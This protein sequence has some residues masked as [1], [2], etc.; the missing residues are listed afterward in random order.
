MPLLGQTE[1]ALCALS[2]ALIVHILELHQLHWTCFEGPFPA[3]AFF[4][5]VAK[6]AQQPFVLKR[7][8]AVV[9]ANCE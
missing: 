9:S 2:I 4:G 7:A 1:N 6:R 3:L 8:T 5:A